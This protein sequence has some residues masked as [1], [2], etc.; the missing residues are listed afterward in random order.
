MVCR[1]KTSYMLLYSD[2]RAWHPD[3][4]IIIC[5][6][7]YHCTT[8]VS[9]Q[10]AIIRLCHKHLTRCWLFQFS[11]L[12]LQQVSG[13]YLMWYPL[14]HIRVISATCDTAVSHTYYIMTSPCKHLYDISGISHF[15]KTMWPQQ[16]VFLLYHKHLTFWHL[17]VT[18]RWDY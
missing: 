2:I 17:C 4:I 7:R 1:A 16:G 14:Y 15:M 18:S 9:Y 3:E 13:I 6:Q 11:A 12:H 8:S 10:W 5:H